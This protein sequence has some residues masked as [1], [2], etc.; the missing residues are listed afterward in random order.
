MSMKN[1]RIMIVEDDQVLAEHVR[2]SLNDWGYIVD[3][4]VPDGEG[5]VREAERKKPNL[6]LMDIQLKGAMSGITASE[7][8]SGRL[9]IPVVFISAH[10]DEAL[11][12][13]T[14][15]SG[16]CGYL[17]KPV[18]ERILKITV[19][20]AL[21]RHKI[22]EA[23]SESEKRYR[24]IIEGMAE[25]Y[26]EANLGGYLTVINEAMAQI[27]G[28]PKEQLLGK[29]NRDFMEPNTAKL[30]YKKFNEVYQTGAPVKQFA[31][32]LITK[33]GR[34]RY[35]EVSIG[36]IKNR[37]NRPIGFRGIARD[38]TEKRKTE[39]SL[40]ETRNFLQNILN[41]SI[42]GICT[43]DMKGKII[44]T[45]PSLQ[46]LL[47]FDQKELI[48]KH[49]YDL[50]KNGKQDAKHIMGILTHHG[51]L[52]NHEMQFVAKDGRELHVMLSASM[53]KEKAGNPIGTLG[54]FK[55][56]TERI[57]MEEQI[58]QSQ[59]HESIGVLAGGIAHDFNN[60][61]TAVVGNISLARMYA[62]AEGKLAQV[63]NEADRACGQGKELTERL[64]NFSPG[65][66]PVKK[67]DAIGKLMQDVTVLALSGSTVSNDFDVPED[68]W[69]V[70]YNADQMKEV[71]VNIVLNAMESMHNKGGVV[72]VTGRNVLL[73]RKRV[74][75]NEVIA[76]GRY[77]QLS[78]TDN[79]VGIPEE[80]LPKIFDPY[81][82]T[83]EQ[84]IEKGMGLGLTSVYSIIKKHGGHIHVESKK[85]SGTTVH[86]FLPAYGIRKREA[87]GIVE[88]GEAPERPKG[89]ILVMDDEE[90]VREV[91]GEMLKEM[92]Y[93]VKFAKEGSEAVEL[94]HKAKGAGAPFE[95]VILDVTVKAGMGGKETLKCLLEIDPDIKAFVSSGYSNEPIM[96][97]HQKYGFI[98]A[99]TKPFSI[100]T[101]KAAVEEKL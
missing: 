94:Y 23:F 16:T 86:I 91:V 12:K 60:L 32:E 29:N 37:E 50:Y 74:D 3:A 53:L 11:V 2:S 77:V 44:F 89:K 47:G 27:V 36:P 90:I 95:A 20:N 52:K 25:G 49:V 28:L 83:K 6:V 61:L 96:L 75:T 63:L 54:I 66:R 76:A 34:S 78:F 73:D 72:R 99:I 22:E 84:G 33:E 41:S 57:K 15:L 19:E 59:K 101:L 69:L 80:N 92:G 4:I 42:D 67:V 21:Y 26:Y 81:F 97:E 1:E 30:V 39:I 45:T 40:I 64:L 31:F 98:G 24:G 82:S 8:I 9:N 68:L 58:L 7:I 85:G 17:L 10:E 62:K 93:T 87:E 18:D 14:R 79:G 35:L 71:F 5:A 51:G 88:L 43:T 100:E 38:I 13:K 70:E 48:G 65:D 56:I 55:D 46:E